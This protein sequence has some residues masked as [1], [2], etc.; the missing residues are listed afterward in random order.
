MG[1]C[2]SSDQGLPNLSLIVG[3]GKGGGP[4]QLQLLI[5]TIVP[6][7]TS[8]PKRASWDMYSCYRGYISSPCGAGGA[9]S[10]QTCSEGD[11]AVGTAGR[12]CHLWGGSAVGTAGRWCRPRGGSAVGTAGR[13]CHPHKTAPARLSAGVPVR[14]LDAALLAR[15]AWCTACAAH[16]CARSRLLP[17]W[18]FCR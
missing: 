15:A 16:T 13:W 1:F 7:V 4:P 3:G 2:P 5:S 12:W 8:T 11:S 14:P 6:P 18:R 9:P 10:Y 17:W